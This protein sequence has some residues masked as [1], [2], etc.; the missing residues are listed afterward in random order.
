MTL[1]YFELFKAFLLTLVAEGVAVMILFRR[2]EYF[3]Y[4]VL[5]NLLTNPAMNILLALSLRLFGREVYYIALIIAELTVVL[6]EAAV[7]NYICGFGIRK[8]AI[9]SLFL[10]ILSFSAGILLLNN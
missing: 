10:N 6:I 7:Y 3:Y 9:L 4:C 8:A 1:P 5:C 2:K